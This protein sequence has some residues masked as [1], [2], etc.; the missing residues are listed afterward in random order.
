MERATNTFSASYLFTA[1]TGRHQK[2]H[3]RLGGRYPEDMVDQS[4]SLI[5]S[6]YFSLPPTESVN[7]AVSLPHVVSLILLLKII[8]VIDWQTLVE[9]DLFCFASL[10]L[11]MGF[12]FCFY[13]IFFFAS[14]ICLFI[15]LFIFVICKYQLWTSSFECGSVIVTSSSSSSSRTDSMNFPESL[16]NHLSP[17]SR[18][19]KLHPVSAQSCFR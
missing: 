13:L 4:W 3:E 14:F 17:P 2:S 9:I 6:A 12:L 7:V 1:F 10:F 16:Y 11:Y 19:L 18:S 5:V 8:F 15:Y